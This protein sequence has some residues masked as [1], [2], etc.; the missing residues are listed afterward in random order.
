MVPSDLPKIG[1]VYGGLNVEYD[2]KEENTE[3]SS[4]N[5]RVGNTIV[6]TTRVS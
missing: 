5:V 4:A 3:V 6:A 2:E 1:M